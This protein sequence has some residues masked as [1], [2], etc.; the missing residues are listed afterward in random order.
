M[1]HGALNGIEQMT[2][3]WPISTKLILNILCCVHNM[4]HSSF[5]TDFM[6][7]TPLCRSWIALLCIYSRLFVLFFLPYLKSE[8]PDH[9]P[10]IVKPHSDLTK[11]Q[12]Y[13]NTAPEKKSYEEFCPP[14]PNC[15]QCPDPKYSISS[16]TCYSA[17][18]NYAS[19]TRVLVS[20]LFN[21]LTIIL[22]TMCL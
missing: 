8:S 6:S 4:H 14:Q 3:G 12:F 16:I 7:F 9:N 1:A 13:G 10:Y 5:Y 20:M 19:S 2:L 11:P 17:T 22:L 21:K 15:P 18:S